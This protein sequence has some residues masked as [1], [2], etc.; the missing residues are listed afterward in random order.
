MSV[1]GTNDGAVGDLCASDYV[2][3]ARRSSM[4]A[5]CTEPHVEPPPAELA[6]VFIDCS[7]PAVMSGNA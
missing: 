3:H 5:R 7:I 1:G 2:S 4:T 6:F